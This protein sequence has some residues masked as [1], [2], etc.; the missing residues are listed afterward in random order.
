[1]SIT[2]VVFDLSVQKIIR[3]GIEAKRKNQCFGIEPQRFI[4]ELSI[5]LAELSEQE[6]HR[7]RSDMRFISLSVWERK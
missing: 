7:E 3:Q 6:K 1:M 5:L 2:V 4:F